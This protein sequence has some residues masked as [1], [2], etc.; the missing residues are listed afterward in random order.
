MTKPEEK[1]S[2]PQKKKKKRKEKKKKKTVLL[3]NCIKMYHRNVALFML[4]QT[5]FHSN[6]I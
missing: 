4:V 1:R 5:Y 6:D 3:T 2:I